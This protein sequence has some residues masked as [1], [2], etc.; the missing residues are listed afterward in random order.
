VL[1]FSK[2]CGWLGLQRLPVPHRVPRVLTWDGMARP[3]A[4]ARRITCK[5]SDLQILI[6]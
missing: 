3:A 1:P 2:L 6:E 5:K 4:I